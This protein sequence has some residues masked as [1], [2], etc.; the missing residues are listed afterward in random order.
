MDIPGANKMDLIDSFR[1]INLENGLDDDSDSNFILESASEHM[2]ATS[3]EAPDNKVSMGASQ[4]SSKG[5]PKV[6]VVDDLPAEEEPSSSGIFHS[7]EILELCHGMGQTVKGCNVNRILGFPMEEV[8]YLCF[9]GLYNKDEN[10]IYVG[11]YI[12][13]VRGQHNHQQVTRDHRYLS[14]SQQMEEGLVLD[15]IF[16]QM[17]A[18]QEAVLL[19]DGYHPGEGRH[20]WDAAWGTFPKH[21]IER[22]LL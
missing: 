4:A 6:I 18:E 16:M 17:S 21:I 22:L 8:L 14:Q 5:G 12:I 13:T 3:G 11:P 2:E 7:W 19:L 20:R 10:E 9:V 15:F 1:T